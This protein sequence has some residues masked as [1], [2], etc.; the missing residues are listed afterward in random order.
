[1]FA[2]L[3]ITTLKERIRKLHEP[4]ILKFHELA[5]FIKADLCDDFFNHDP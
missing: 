1:M 3:N 4:P 2:S 5:S